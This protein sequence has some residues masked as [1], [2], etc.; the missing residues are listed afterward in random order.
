M[1]IRGCVG[2][3]VGVEVLDFVGVVLV[4]LVRYKGFYDGKRTARS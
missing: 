4:S 2:G 1:G 3:L